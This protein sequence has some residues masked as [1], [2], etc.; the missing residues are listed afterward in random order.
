MPSKIENTAKQIRKTIDHAYVH[1]IFET[2]DLN[3]KALRPRRGQPPTTR[4]KEDKERVST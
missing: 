4:S 2:L 1:S 3:L